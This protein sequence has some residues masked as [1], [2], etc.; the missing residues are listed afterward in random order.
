MS[1][2]EQLTPLCWSTDTEND[3]AYRFVDGNGTPIDITG[4]VIKWSSKKALDDATFQIAAITLT[5]SD[6]VTNTGECTGTANTPSDDYEGLYQV[7][8]QAPG[9]SKPKVINP[10]G[11]EITVDE[12]MV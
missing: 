12:K 6:Q 9:M 2:K 4:W 7:E 11:T 8:F 10:S 3:I 1:C 5:I